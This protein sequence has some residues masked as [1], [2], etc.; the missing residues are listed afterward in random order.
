MVAAARRLAR[1]EVGGRSVPDDAVRDLGA[2][3]RSELSPAAA[4]ELSHAGI[5]RG[6]D[7]GRGWARVA[8]DATAAAVEPLGF[9]GW[10]LASLHGD[11]LELL[12]APVVYWSQ[13]RVGARL[14]A[15]RCGVVAVVLLLLLMVMMM[16]LRHHRLV[17]GGVAFAVSAVVLATEHGCV[18]AEDGLGD[19]GGDREGD[20][21][22]GVVGRLARRVVGEAGE[23]RALLVLG[24]EQLAR[25]VVEEGQ[26]G[27]LG[28]GDRGALQHLEDLAEELAVLGRLVEVAL[29]AAAVVVDAELAVVAVGDRAEEGARSAFRLRGFV[30]GLVGEAG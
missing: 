17:M 6:Y 23:G 10:L 9:L 12:V 24:R 18:N 16:L 20:D 19:D 14:L 22:A 30:A 21:A 2:G 29:E 4:L 5:G 8:V 3:E 13:D 28:L 25:G 7:V 15:L 11:V 26:L 27:A 1:V